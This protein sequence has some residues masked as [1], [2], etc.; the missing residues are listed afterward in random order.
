MRNHAFTFF[1]SSICHQTAFCLAGGF[2]GG[3]D[4]FGLLTGLVALF[5]FCFHFRCIYRPN[6]GAI[7]MQIKRFR[8]EYVTIGLKKIADF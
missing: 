8:T 4:G 7:A 2:S 6:T 3:F 1:G 5:S